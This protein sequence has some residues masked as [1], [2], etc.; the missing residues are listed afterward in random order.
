[1]LK[2][3]RMHEDIR[4]PVRM[5]G[6]SVGYDICVAEDYFLSPG[7]FSILKTGLIVKPPEGFHIEIALRSS[8]PK[9]KGCAIPNGLGIID[10]DYCG[11]GDE[12]GIPIYKFGLGTED[13]PGVDGLPCTYFSAGERIAQIIL[14]KT[15]IVDVIDMSSNL[16]DLKSGRGGF[17]S[18]GNI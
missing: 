5:T 8:I 13:F 12:L 11:L 17:G 18:T 10:A 4:L 15:Y 16:E 6:G 3:W 2:V 7:D 14:R 9:K 1:M